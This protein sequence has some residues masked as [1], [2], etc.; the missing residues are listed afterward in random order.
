MSQSSPPQPSTSPLSALGEALRFLTI[1]PI[2]GLPPM[3]EH[4]IVRAMPFFP[5]AG[6]LIGAATAAIGWGAGWLWGDLVRAVALVVAGAVLTAG[7]HLDG[8]ADSCDALFSWRPRERKL[9]IMKDS[10]IGTMGALGLFTVI[11]LKVAAYASLG[12]YWWQAALLA[13]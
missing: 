12:T 6:L 8:V 4:G 11:L 3:T 7:L 5:V 13:P 9:E 2:P 10:R 1:I